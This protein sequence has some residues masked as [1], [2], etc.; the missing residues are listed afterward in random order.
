M[1][2]VTVEPSTPTFTW[3]MLEWGVVTD[4]DDIAIFRTAAGSSHF[5]F[6]G[7]TEGYTNSNGVVVLPGQLGFV[8]RVST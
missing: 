3:K 1:L 6:A 2:M 4:G 7:Y 5:Y 8:T